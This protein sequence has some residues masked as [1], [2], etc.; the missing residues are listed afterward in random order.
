MLLP[1]HLRENRPY[2]SG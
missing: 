1:A 2:P